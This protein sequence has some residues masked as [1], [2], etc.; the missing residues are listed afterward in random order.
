MYGKSALIAVVAVASGAWWFTSSSH[1]KPSDAKK[2][3]LESGSKVEGSKHTEKLSGP[4][5]VRI[6]LEGTPPDEAGDVYKLVGYVRTDQVFSNARIQWL[7]PST[8]EW[9][10]GTVREQVSLSPEKE[11][12][13]ELTLK[14]KNSAPQ[15]VQLRASA[16]EN[17]S[18]FAA[19]GHYN[20][21]PVKRDF[22]DKK[23]SLKG[24]EETPQQEQKIFH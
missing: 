3:I 1:G 19:S 23:E 8:A 7:I 24:G 17:R 21:K 6:E 20:N 11:F 13:T 10:S 4:M 22:I 16:S 14:A 9:V 2:A 5:E 15:R 18:R 12:R